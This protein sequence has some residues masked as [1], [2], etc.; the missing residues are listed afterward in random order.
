MKS[1]KQINRISKN[2]LEREF[3]GKIPYSTV[4]RSFSG[5]T[6][7]F[8][9]SNRGSIPR[10]AAKPSRLIKNKSNSPLHIDGY[11]YISCDADWK[12]IRHV[13]CY[14]ANERCENGSCSIYTPV[15]NGEADHIYGR[16]GGK[17]EDRIL[18]VVRDESGQ[19]INIKRYLQWLCV[20]CHREKHNQT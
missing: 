6:D 17:R 18:V 2:R 9:T 5:R 19:I 4:A 20:F 14:M 8:G 10:R 3:H 15:N 1:K 16:G 11:R 12:R 7:A 13:L